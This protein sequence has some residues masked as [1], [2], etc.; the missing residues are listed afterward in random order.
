[1]GV[2]SRWHRAELMLTLLPNE[3]GVVCI[4]PQA[5][6]HLHTPHDAPFPGV[7]LSTGTEDYFDS[8]YYFDGGR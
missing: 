8:A 6:Y 4:V 7:V 2:L 1:M 3:Y 5:C